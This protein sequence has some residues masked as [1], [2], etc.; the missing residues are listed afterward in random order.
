MNLAAREL[1][2]M[3]VSMGEVDGL[4]GEEAPSYSSQSGGK[5]GGKNNGKSNDNG[6]N[7]DGDGK[8]KYLGSGFDSLGPHPELVNPPHSTSRVTTKTG[9]SGKGSSNAMNPGLLDGGST[10]GSQ[11][12]SATGSPVGGSSRSSSGAAGIR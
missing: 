11:G 2:Q 3:G 5:S 12:P 8:N 1:Q 4:S 9:A 7:P 10:L 6:P